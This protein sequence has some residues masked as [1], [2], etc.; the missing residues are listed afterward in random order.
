VKISL[1]FPEFYYMRKNLVFIPGLG[2]D[3][4]LWQHQTRHLEDLASIQVAIADGPSRR[5]MA[6]AILD[7]SPAKFALIGHSLGG[8]VAQEIAAIAPDRVEKLILVSTWARYNERF[9]EAIRYFQE[10][11]RGEDLESYLR[12]NLYFCLHADRLYEPALTEAIVAMELAFPR[13]IYLEQ[14]QVMIEEKETLP[15]LASIA[16]PTLVIHGRQD[17]IFGLEESQVIVDRIPQARLTIIEEC[18]HMIPL[19]RPQALTALCRLWLAQSGTEV[20]T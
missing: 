4:R 14:S 7:R 16:C 9:L 17:L 6:E 3:E 19:E 11:L 8:W 18:G 5:S 20:P 12:D 15:L 10:K 1:L 13:T 2:C